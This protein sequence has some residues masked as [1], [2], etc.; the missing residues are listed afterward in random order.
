MLVTD[1]V[2][3]ARAFAEKPWGAA[4]DAE[5]AMLEAAKK[6]QREEDDAEA[7]RLA[8]EAAENG[9]DEDAFGDD[10]DDLEPPKDEL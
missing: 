8:A 1:D 5:K 7:K 10:Y 3:Y 6:K 2:E 4:R 9:D